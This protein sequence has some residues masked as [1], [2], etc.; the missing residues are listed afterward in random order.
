MGLQ[1][2]SGA[3]CRVVGGFGHPGAEVALVDAV[4]IFVLV[5]SKD[6]PGGIDPALG[7]RGDGTR[8]HADFAASSQ[9]DAVVTAFGEDGAILLSQLLEGRGSRHV[10]DTSHTG[11]VFPGRVT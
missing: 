9:G 11:I 5:L 8:P 4:L 2:F 3:G 7:S 10:F 1:E 6:G